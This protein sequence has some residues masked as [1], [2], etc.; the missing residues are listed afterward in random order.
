MRVRVTR[1]GTHSNAAHASITSM[2]AAT[3]WGRRSGVV[4]AGI[5]TW[6]EG[7]RSV[8]TDWVDRRAR[9][10]RCRASVDSPVGICVVIIAIVV[11]RCRAKWCSLSFDDVVKANLRCVFVGVMVSI[12]PV[13]S[14][15]LISSLNLAANMHSA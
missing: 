10:R 12:I 11:C 4:G 5:V 7:T 2:T 15:N 13:S 3:T 9:N 6:R 1:S 14:R 8:Q